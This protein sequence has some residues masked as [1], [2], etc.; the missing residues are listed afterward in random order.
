MII[1]RLADGR[2][3]AWGSLELPDWYDAGIHAIDSLTDEFRAAWLDL[4]PPYRWADGTYHVEQ[5]QA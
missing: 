1:Y 5:E 3:Q 2:V 4:P